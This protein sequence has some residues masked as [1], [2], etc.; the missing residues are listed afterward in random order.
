MNHDHLRTFLIVADQK[1]F[2]KAARI[3]YLSQ[4]TITSHIKALENHLN[5]SLFIRTRQFVELTQAG[6]IL[7]PYAKNILN[8]IVKVQNEIEELMGEIHGKLKIASSLTIGESILPSLLY[9]FK[10][11]YP[12]VK[13]ETEIINS[14]NIVEMVKNEELEIGLI[15]AEL[16]E[17][18]IEMEPFMSDELVL[19]ARKG[20]FT[21]EQKHIGLEDLKSTPII[22]REKGSGTRTVIN[23]CLEKSGLN[24]E[25]LSVVLELGSTESVKAAVEAGLGFSILSKHSIRKELSLEIFETYR[26]ENVELNRDFYMAYKKKRQLSLISELFIKLIKNSNNYLKNSASI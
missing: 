16:N 2:S 8:T 9:K 23:Q 20:F 19:V 14:K 4:P 21:M 18:T 26:I 10:T 24:P 3:L 12:R 5:A 15:E 13:L 1:S 11:Q 22:L 7:Y 25:E 6:N 17:P